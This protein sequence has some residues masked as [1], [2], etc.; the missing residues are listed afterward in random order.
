M[1]RFSSVVLLLVVLGFLTPVE[2]ALIDRGGGMIYDTG[3]NITW[4]D[5]SHQGTW[6]QANAWAAGL[7]VGGVTG[8][9]LTQTLPVNGSTYN[10]NFS[11]NGSTDWGFNISAPGSAYPGFKGNELAYLY[12]VDLGNKGYF[13][14]NGN[15]QS[16]SGLVNTGPFKNL[17]QQD[18]YYLSGTEYPTQPGWTAFLFPF[19]SNANDAGCQGGGNEYID[20]Y[21]ALAV[22]SG[23]VGAPV[24]IPG[25]VWLLGSGL[26]GLI[27][28]AK[29]K[30]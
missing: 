2:A 18:A 5:N 22:H 1:K 24:P 16:G 29:L 23:D 25:A 11:Y 21:Y 30:K 20:N 15:K 19:S 6:Y 26:A 9:R 10:Q 4:Y 27:G 17:Q 28:F 3:L 13:D 14:V 12:Y 8:W 7:N